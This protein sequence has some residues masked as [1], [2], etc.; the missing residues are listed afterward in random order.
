[1]SR[2]IYEPSPSTGLSHSLVPPHVNDTH[3]TNRLLF[4]PPWCRMFSPRRLCFQRVVIPPRKRAGYLYPA[5]HTLK[6]SCYGA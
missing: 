4:L 3:W 5:T 2:S 6:E 1:M